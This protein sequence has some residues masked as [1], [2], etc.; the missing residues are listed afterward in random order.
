[1]TDSSDARVNPP[2]IKNVADLAGVSVGTVS[3]VLNGG[4]NVSAAARARVEKAIQALAYS[5]N[6]MARRL[7]TGRSGAIGFST[8]DITNPL[9]SQLAR[10]FQDLLEKR[11]FTLL[12]SNA[13]DDPAR[14]QDLVRRFLEQS[15]DGLILGPG[16]GDA[17]KIVELATA[18]G[19]PLVVLD[20]EAPEP[21]VRVMSEHVP[22]L[23]QATNYLLDL[24]HRNIAIMTGSSAHMAGRGR[25]EGFRRAF[26]DRDLDVPEHFI[27]QGEFSRAFGEKA[28]RQLLYGPH[29]PTAIICGGAP[30]L[31][32]AL[33]VIHS[34]ELSI[35][36][37]L[38][39]IGC[40]DFD[41]T[42]LYRPAI[43]V[44]RRN[45][46]ELGLVA[47]EALIDLIQGA[48][49]PAQSSM[50]IRTELVVRDSCAPPGAVTPRLRPRP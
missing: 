29:P 50:R 17:T 9:F 20:R 35:P 41:V 23:R 8:R 5:P 39:L 1:M 30:L 40:D 6:T 42:L 47:A 38:S 16:I 15:V 4:A 21:A 32:G 22:G 46:D 26:R 18:Q 7:R 34:A 25:V 2:K 28:A 14:E 11:G 12:V 33:P 48:R 44:V 27:L 49:S 19:V 45:F 13:F 43:T 36:D 31:L 10:A 24:G 3:R 37:D